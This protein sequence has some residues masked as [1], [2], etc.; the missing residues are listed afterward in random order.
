MGERVRVREVIFI[1]GA[2][3]AVQLQGRFANRPC[4]V[5]RFSMRTRYYFAPPWVL[6]MGA[7]AFFSVLS[8]GATFLAA[9]LALPLSADCVTF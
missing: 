1:V 7:P 3:N 8:F 6:S 2:K 9:S 5:C 4:R